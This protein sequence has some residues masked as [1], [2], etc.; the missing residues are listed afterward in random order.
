MKTKSLGIVL[1]IAALSTVGAYFALSR[2]TK[3]AD[4]EP[5]APFLPELSTKAGSIDRIELERGATKIELVRDGVVWRLSSSD[6]YPARFEEIK[7]LVSGVSSLKTDQKMTAQK[8]RQT[9]LALAWPDGGGRA[10]RARLLAGNE[11]VADII[12]GE[13]RANPRAQFV[14]REAEDQCWRVLGSV[15]VEIEPR[16]WVD[17]E[18]LAIPE[19]EVR[20]VFVNGL[21]ISSTESPEGKISYQVVENSPLVMAT[22]YE[23]TAPRSAVAQRT[24]PSWLSRLELDDVRRAKVGGVSGGAIDPALSPEFDMVRGTLKINAVRDGDAVWISFDAKAK[25]GAPSAAEMNA[26][27]KYPGDPYVPDWK[28]FAAKHTGWQYKL[29]LW[30]LNSLEE[31]TKTPIATEKPTDPTAPT[32]VPSPG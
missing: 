31:A 23:W 29:P 19:G 6:G 28:D 9:E 24:L 4:F 25:D 8:D 13:E 32:V 21:H 18:L 12:L 3:T 5:G 26:K 22:D 20:A 17:A 16:R 2:G 14:R 1:G 10:A 27:K 15:L 30:K 7:G 11:T